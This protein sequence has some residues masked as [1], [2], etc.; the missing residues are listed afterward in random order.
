MSAWR[1]SMSSTTKG[2]EPSRPVSGGSRPAVLAASS[3]ERP[4]P[5][6]ETTPELVTVQESGVAEYDVVSW[7]ALFA[8]AGTPPEIVKTLKFT[9]ETG[10][11]QYDPV[12][13]KIY[14]NLQDE[15][16][17]AVIDPA[18]S[19]PRVK[20]VRRFNDLL[21]GESRVSATVIQTVGSKG[22]DGFALALVT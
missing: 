1:H 2:L 18:T 6:S 8:R 9:S 13:R 22:Y 17:F 14:V 4:P 19:D 10:M 12:A 21:A 7:N 5:R 16:T 3:R 11:P 20:G 15:D